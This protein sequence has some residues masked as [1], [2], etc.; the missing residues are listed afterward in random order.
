VYIG[1]G[2]HRVHRTV[3]YT[4]TV[5]NRNEGHCKKTVGLRKIWSA[6][7]NC[8]YWKYNPI[9]EE[10]SIE[11]GSIPDKGLFYSESHPTCERESV[12]R[13][14]ATGFFHQTISPGPNRHVQEQ[15]RIY[16][17]IRG[18]IRICN[19]LLGDE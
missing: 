19:R 8:I 13:F 3:L 16:S 2:E 18:V 12:T 9:I 10:N 15:F 6:T 4:T 7:Y 1:R 11:R 14:F 5:R 17:N